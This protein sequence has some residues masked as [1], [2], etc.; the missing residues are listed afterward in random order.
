MSYLVPIADVIA[1]CV[2]AI[3]LYFP[4]HRRHDLAMAY[5]AVNISVLGVAT[6]LSSTPINAGVGFGLFGVLALIRL[7]SE[8]LT[9]REIAYYFCSLALGIIGGLGAYH[10]WLSI[11]LMALIVVVLAVGDATVFSR[12]SLTQTVTFREAITDPGE[13]KSA[14]EALLQADVVSVTPVKVDFVKHFTVAEVRYRPSR[15]PSIVRSEDSTLVPAMS[16]TG[17]VQTWYDPTTSRPD[18]PDPS[19]PTPY[20]PTRPSN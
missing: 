3:V 2:L 4:R 1:V 18:T 8:K 10:A 5:V 20:D 14:V 19:T 17:P 12:A 13:L 7:R 6:A 9:Q 11:G 16:G 15:N